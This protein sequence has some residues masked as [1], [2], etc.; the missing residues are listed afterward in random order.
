MRKY[1][2]IATVTCLFSTSCKK[3]YQCINE[4]D[5]ATGEVKASTQKKATKLCPQGSG[6]VLK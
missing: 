2:F 5:V 4:V 1:F 3:T 6:A